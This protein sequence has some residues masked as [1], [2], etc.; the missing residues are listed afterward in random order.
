[1]V[2][3]KNRKTEKQKNRKTE[4]QK[5]RKTEKQKNRKTEKQRSEFIEKIDAVC[6]I[7][8]LYWQKHYEISLKA[9][10]RFAN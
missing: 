5:N 2:K 6:I 9:G 3:Q 10:K 1:M 4:K 7:L 8:C